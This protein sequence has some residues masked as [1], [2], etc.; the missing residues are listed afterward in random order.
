MSS[1]V[2]FFFFQAEDGIR[3]VAVTGVQTCA[4][5]ISSEVGGNEQ[6]TEHLGSRHHKQDRTVRLKHDNQHQPGAVESRGVHL[7]HNFRYLS[8]LCH[9][10]SY[11]RGSE[12]VDQDGT[13]DGA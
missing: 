13:Y 12:Q 6:Q 10:A 3:D 5:P 7:G 9:S 1:T 8:K 2:V 4:L 11:E